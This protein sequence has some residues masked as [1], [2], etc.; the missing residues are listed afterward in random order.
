V[1][2]LVGEMLH[3]KRDSTIT[4][5]YDKRRTGV[6]E[7]KKE[8]RERRRKEEGGKDEKKGGRQRRDEGRKKVNR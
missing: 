8:V 7:V 3:R 5:T 6:G 1:R 2:D 4:V